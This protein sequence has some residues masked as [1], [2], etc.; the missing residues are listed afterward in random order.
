[1][2]EI[3]ENTSIVGDEYDADGTVA[4]SIY[5]SRAD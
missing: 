5:I 3:L 2:P 1:M 4:S